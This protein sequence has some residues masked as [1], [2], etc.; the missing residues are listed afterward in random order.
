MLNYL[1]FASFPF[2][3]VPVAYQHPAEALV[4]PSLKPYVFA[5]AFCKV[6]CTFPRSPTLVSPAFSS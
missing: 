5:Y 4:D 2:A 3:L 6:S 1:R